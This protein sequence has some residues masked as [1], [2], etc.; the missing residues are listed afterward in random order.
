MI[1]FDPIILIFL[2]FFLSY[3]FGSFPSGYVLT[4]L[5]LNIDIRD[6]GSGNV[7]STNVL[8]AGSKIIA[9]ITLLLDILKGYIPVYLTIKFSNELA[10]IAGISA[11]IGHIFPIWL[12]FKGGKGIATF[13]G[14][15]S[16]ISL[17]SGFVFILSWLLVAIVTKKSSIASL[18]SCLIANIFIY[19]NYGPYLGLFVTCLYVLSI[20]MHK[21]NIERIIKGNEPKIKF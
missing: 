19:V 12:K 15:I 1:F 16:G 13:I 2:V 20:F 4:R 5:F 6:L 17:I 8:R 7:G 3:L 11:F 18:L 14:I 10:Y 21:D 9:F